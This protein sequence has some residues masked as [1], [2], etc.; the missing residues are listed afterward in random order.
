M[1]LC[2]DFARRT[3]AVHFFM[4]KMADILA[5]ATSVISPYLSI[6]IF[7]IHKMIYKRR[8]PVLINPVSGLQ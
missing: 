3:L 6:D 8:T 1:R 4:M 7:L 5:K 2:N